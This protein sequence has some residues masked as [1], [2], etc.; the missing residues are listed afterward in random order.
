MCYD[1]DVE[2]ERTH[3]QPGLVILFGSGETSASGQKVFDWLLRRLPSPA[4]VAIVETPAG[5]ELNSAQVAGRIGEFLCHR[6]QNYQPQVTVV[7]ARKRGTPFSPDNPEIAA[8]IPGAHAIFLGPGS[9]TYAVRQL[10]GSLTWQ[11]AVAC[12]M[13]GAALILASAAT[14][15]IGAH[16]LPVYEIYKVG[17][18]LHWRDGLDLFRPYGL[19]LALIPHWNNSDGGVDLDTSRCWMGRSRFEQLAAM[20]PPGV[21][22]IGIDEHTAVVLDLAAGSCQVMGRGGAS[23]LRGGKERRVEHGHS[24]PLSEWGPFHEPPGGTELPPEVRE[25]VHRAQAPVP[26]KMALDPPPEVVLLA[27]ERE[28]A[29]VRLDWATADA[30]R[31]QIAALGWQVLDTQAGPQ[32]QWAKSGGK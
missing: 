32:L 14:V 17:E 16:T 15:A 19:S 31:G 3:D 4:R 8:L 5:F 2:D 25:L 12:H 26:S 7:P 1:C 13:L 23:V 29:R 22:V 28:A 11:T 18:E 9:P 20:L 27:Q 6:L 21:T 24:L 30:L 10:Q